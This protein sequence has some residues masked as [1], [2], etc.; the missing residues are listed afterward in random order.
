MLSVGWESGLLGR[1]RSRAICVRR[2]GLGFVACFAV[3]VSKRKATRTVADGG[4][5]RAIAVLQIFLHPHSGTRPPGPTALF[6]TP[7]PRLGAD[8]E[9]AARPLLNEFVPA[10]SVE[11]SVFG[12]SVGRLRKSRKAVL[13]LRLDGLLAGCGPAGAA[14]FAGGAATAAGAAA[15]CGGSCGGHDWISFCVSLRV[16]G[17]TPSSSSRIGGS[18][19]IGP[20]PIMNSLN[21]ALNELGLTQSGRVAGF[22]GSSTLALRALMCGK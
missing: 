21:C 6:I 3:G 4:R 19:G 1:Y 20:A 14:P 2:Y 10:R 17:S 15:G 9:H 18:G 7:R 8:V 16:S 13:L 11:R 12:L 22:G 5:R